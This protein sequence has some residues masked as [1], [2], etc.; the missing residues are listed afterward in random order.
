MDIKVDEKVYIQIR[1]FHQKP[2]YNNRNER[3]FHFV[4]NRI[5]CASHLINNR[6]ERMSHLLKNRIEWASQNREIDHSV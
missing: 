2:A 6:I 1:L 3:V 5:E 4:N